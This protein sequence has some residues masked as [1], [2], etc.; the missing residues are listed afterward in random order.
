MNDPLRTQ[1]DLIAT[2]RIERAVD[3]AGN[4][5]A[6][7]TRTPDPRLAALER[8]AKGHRWR[9]RPAGHAAARPRFDAQLVPRHPLRI[10]RVEALL[11]VEPR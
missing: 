7:G 4:A 9:L 8:R 2:G 6:S 11:R 1:Q 10:L 5:L 3:P